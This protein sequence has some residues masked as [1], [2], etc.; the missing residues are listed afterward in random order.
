MR[1]IRLDPRFPWIID[2]ILPVQ[3]GIRWDPIPNITEGS[4]GIQDLPSNF[5]MGSDWIMDPVLQ[6][7][8][9]SS[10]IIDPTLGSMDMSGTEGMKKIHRNMLRLCQSSIVKQEKGFYTNFI[11]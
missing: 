10:G 2:P 6:L 3:S 7:V 9:R 8:E 1:R 4:N 5:T 11:S